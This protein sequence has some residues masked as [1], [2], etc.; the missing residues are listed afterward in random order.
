M[1]SYTTDIGKNVLKATKDLL[2]ASGAEG[3]LYDDE[4]DTGAV[5]VFEFDH[6]FEEAQIRCAAHTVQL[7]VND[8]GRS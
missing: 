6:P 4:E 8:F 7:G 3:A 5:A 1:Y 2:K